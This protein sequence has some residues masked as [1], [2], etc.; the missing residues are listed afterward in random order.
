MSKFITNLK[1]SW[2]KKNSLVCVGLDTDLEKIPEHLKTHEKP[3]FE[4]NKAIIDATV[5]F[6]S[7][8]KLQYA[9]YAGQDIVDQLIESVKYIKENYP[10]VPVILDAKRNDIGNTAAMYVKEVFDIIG[11]DAVTI[12]PYLGGDSLEPFLEQKDKGIIILCRTSNPGARDLQDLEVE[13]KKLYQI[14]AEKTVKEWNKNGNCLLVVGATY[15]EELKKIR[16]IVGD[17]PFLM[18]GIGAQG[19]EVKAAVE[20]GKDSNGQGMII[21]SARVIIY[22]SS[23]RDFAESSAKK[24]KE[25]RDKINKYR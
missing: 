14:V 18:P 15:P 21:H 5:D 10:E 13:G 16:Q 7:T 12:T 24:A 17:I 22:A 6:V 19:G 23:D 8:F 2:D 1:A 20:N 4:F 25:L 3:A 11:A 9:F